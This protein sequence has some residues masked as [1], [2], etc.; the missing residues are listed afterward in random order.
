VLGEAAWVAPR[1]EAVAAGW[2]GSLPEAHL[3]RIGDVVVACRGLSAIVAT[4]S[5]KP[6]V[7]R[8]VAYHGS[9][10]ATEMAV[11]LLIVR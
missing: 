8:L 1:E 7:S 3:R 4:R 5:E 10:T 2:F 6:I 9:N 11:P